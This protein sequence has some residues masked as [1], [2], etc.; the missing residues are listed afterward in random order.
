MELTRESIFIEDPEVDAHE[1]LRSLHRSS[2]LSLLAQRWTRTTGSDPYMAA[3][4][5]C[6]LRSLH[7]M[8]FLPLC[9]SLFLTAGILIATAIAYSASFIHIGAIVILLY[10]AIF[11]F[12]YCKR[13]ADKITAHI[14]FVADVNNLSII[15]FGVVDDFAARPILSEHELLTGVRARCAQFVEEYG[16]CATEIRSG[17]TEPDDEHPL[18][19]S[20]VED[21]RSTVVL[22][23]YK[24]G[25]IHDGKEFFSEF[26]AQLHAI[27]PQVVRA[28]YCLTRAE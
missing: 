1:L 9:V 7:R 25:L 13:Q 14:D 22:A 18:L 16:A 5:Y 23:T 20:I 19:R 2:H 21:L 4:H 24:F 15:L 26:T 28:H 12:G 17:G 8:L 11:L 10:A 3:R 27:V 6:K